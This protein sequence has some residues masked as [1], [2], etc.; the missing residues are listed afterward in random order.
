M[1][2][3]K[4]ME[5]MQHIIIKVTSILFISILLLNLS[6]AAPAIDT[7]R[8]ITDKLDIIIYG[9]NEGDTENITK[10]FSPNMNRSLSREIVSSIEGKS[11]R[12]SFSTSSMESIGENKLKAKGRISAEGESWSV[13]GMSNHYTFEKID[14]EWYLAD[15]NFHEKTGAGEVA[16]FVGLIFLIIGGVFVM[17]G[18]PLLAF[19]VWMIIDVAKRDFESKIVWLLIVILAGA[20]GA[21]I[22]FF[23]KRRKLKG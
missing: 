15:T 2:T 22:Y 7:Q 20:I 19:W 11:I 8:K 21:A 9:I 1:L 12:Y 16:K 6:S 17:I 18:L 10:I 23:A 3:I 4:I 14:G 13:S 5:K